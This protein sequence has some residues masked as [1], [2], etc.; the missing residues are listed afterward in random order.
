MSMEFRNGFIDEI[1][2]IIEQSCQQAIRS[3]DHL[4]V[5]MYWELGRKIVEEEQQGSER[6]QYGKFILTNLSRA[7]IPIFGSGYSYRQLAYFRQFY[8][9]F[10]NVNALRSHFS[11]THYRILIK[12]DKLIT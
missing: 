5:R 12:I 1:K 9:I 4:R 6:A 3:V 11:W 8:N 2:I 10:S 7:L